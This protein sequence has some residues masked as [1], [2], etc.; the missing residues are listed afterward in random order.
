MRIALLATA[1]V[2]LLLGACKPSQPAANDA[3][4]AT[5]NAPAEAAVPVPPIDLSPIDPAGAMARMHERH[6]GMKTVGKTMKSLARSIKSDPVDMA[7]VA[8]A[9]AT[10]ARLSGEA[11]TWF[12]AGTGPEI[13]KTGAKPEIWQKPDEFKAKLAAWHKA[14][15]AFDAAARSG[16]PAATK[17]AFGDL[18]K[19]CKSCHDNFRNEMKH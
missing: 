19:S 14:A 10:M 7:A 18:G 13:G 17:A 2:A 12:R 6:Q 9:A 4:P 1:T 5:A 11:A 15:M 8:P 3:A 16:D